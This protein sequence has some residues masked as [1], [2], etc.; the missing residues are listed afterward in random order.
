[1]FTAIGMLF[2]VQVDSLKYLQ[3]EWRKE[4]KASTE[5]VRIF[6]IYQLN[7]KGRS[8]GVNCISEN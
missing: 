6:R 1:M 8:P 5:D 4:M 7:T 2:S 3:K